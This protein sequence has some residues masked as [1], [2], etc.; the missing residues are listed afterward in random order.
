MQYI[1]VTLQVARQPELGRLNKDMLLEIIAAVADDRRESSLKH[2]LSSNSLSDGWWNSLS[3][4]WWN[5]LSDGWWT[6]LSDGW[7]NSLSDG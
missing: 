4:E 6:N 7:I 2:E 1:L 3:D 5:S